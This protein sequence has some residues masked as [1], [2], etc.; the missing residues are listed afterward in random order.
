MAKYGKTDVKYKNKVAARE[1]VPCPHAQPIK[2]FYRNYV[3]LNGQIL[4]YDHIQQ[5][6]NLSK[7]ISTH[8]PMT[9]SDLV[10]ELGSFAFCVTLLLS[11]TLFI[12]TIYDYLLKEVKHDGIRTS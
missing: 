3:S 6:Q 11:E 2:T 4:E 9:K 8:A 1:S 10:I 12:T 5:L 7:I